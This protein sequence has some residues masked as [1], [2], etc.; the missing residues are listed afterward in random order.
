MQSLIDWV[1]VS[2]WRG[3]EVTQWRELCIIFDYW[4]MLNLHW[5]S[6]KSRAINLRCLTSKFKL[7]KQICCYSFGTFAVWNTT[8]LFC[9]KQNSKYCLWLW[10]QNMLRCLRSASDC[11]FWFV[12]FSVFVVGIMRKALIFTILLTLSCCG[13][14]GGGE[15]YFKRE[16]SGA[17]IDRKLREANASFQS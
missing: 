10:C 3:Y 2:F 8:R 13:F 1:T 9:L 16:Y 15:A 7:Y 12:N 11:H 5:L 6:E 14:F 4:L 17:K